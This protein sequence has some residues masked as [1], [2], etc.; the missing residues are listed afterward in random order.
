MAGYVGWDYFKVSQLYTPSAQ[1]PEMFR[2][3]TFAKVGGSFIFGSQVIFAQVVT[4]DL[5][6]DNAASML[7][8]ATL[9]LHLSA[10]PR[11]IEKVIDSAVMLGKDDLAKWHL[12]R[13]QRAYP[14]DYK[15][16][17]ALNPVD[18]QR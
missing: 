4:T 15:R 3:D 2:S 1:R 9:S 14:A 10:E 7:D 8:A 13:Y 18:V 16:W 17:L 6:R 11:V 12:L 5:T